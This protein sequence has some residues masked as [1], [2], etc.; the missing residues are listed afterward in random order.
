MSSALLHISQ[1]MAGVTAA[2]RPAL[3]NSAG[4]VSPR[5][6]DISVAANRAA[7]AR[8]P[9]LDALIWGMEAHDRPLR[10]SRRGSP[11]SPSPLAS[12]VR[13]RPS[14]FVL[15]AAADTR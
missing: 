13:V 8:R 12:A 10:R 6:H 5:A 14:C 4:G 7:N 2:P 1:G 9:C 3:V 11:A 15:R